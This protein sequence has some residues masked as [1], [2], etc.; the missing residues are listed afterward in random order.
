M[1]SNAICRRFYSVNELMRMNTRTQPMHTWSPN[2]RTNDREKKAVVISRAY[3]RYCLDI[4]FYRR[5]HLW[6]VIHIVAL[7]QSAQIC[8]LT[9]IILLQTC[10]FTN[11]M[12][13]HGMACCGESSQHI[14]YIFGV[15]Y[16][17]FNSFTTIRATLRT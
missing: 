4:A 9:T 2:E 16:T 5:Q 12:Q 8:P 6:C 14:Y 1:S 10:Q 17:F 11:Y 15:A 3:E 13:S 7:S